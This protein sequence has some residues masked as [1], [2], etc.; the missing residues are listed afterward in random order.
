VPS[1]S[2]QRVRDHA[3]GGKNSHHVRE[4]WTEPVIRKFNTIEVLEEITQKRRYKISQI[5][6]PTPSQFVDGEGKC[7]SDTY[8]CSDTC[9]CR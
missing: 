9:F 4:K 8:L 5:R 6:V 2:V 3:V 1:G 7:G